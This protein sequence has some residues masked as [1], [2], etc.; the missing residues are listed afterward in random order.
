LR[1]ILL[2]HRIDFLQSLMRLIGLAG[3]PSAHH[4]FQRRIDV[5][6]RSQLFL[7]GRRKLGPQ[8]LCLRR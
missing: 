3:A 7:I 5:D 8:R 4:I 2:C 6:K 1:N